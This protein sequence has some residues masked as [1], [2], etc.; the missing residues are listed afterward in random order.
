MMKVTKPIHQQ[1]KDAVRKYITQHA[2]GTYLTIEQRL[3]LAADWNE[4]I[5]AGCQ[6]MIRQ[7]AAKHG[8]RP[9]T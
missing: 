2:P 1:R 3:T 6:F 8:L 9:E 7:F 5:R 4:L